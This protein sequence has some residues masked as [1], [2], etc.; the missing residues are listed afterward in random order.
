MERAGWWSREASAAAPMPAPAPEP[1]P[2]EPELTE[3]HLDR[4][5]ELYAAMYPDRVARI[6]A[7]GG[8]PPDL[9]FGPPEPYI[10]AG[11]LRRAGLA[12]RDASR[13]ETHLMECATETSA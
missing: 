2:A 13:R 7:A 8:L 6:C 1:E 3:A 5:V 10:V 12:P 9:D 4:E 11:L